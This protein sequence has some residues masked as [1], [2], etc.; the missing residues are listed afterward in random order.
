M[1]IIFATFLQCTNS[2]MFRFYYQELLLF[3]IK[4]LFSEKFHLKMWSIYLSAMDEFSCTCLLA[5]F[6]DYHILSYYS[7]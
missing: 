3:Y 5:A 4:E 6:Q 7:Q 2:L 1:I